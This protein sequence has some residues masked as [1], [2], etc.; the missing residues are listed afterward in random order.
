MKELVEFSLDDGDTMV[1]EI[2]QPEAE[3]GLVRAA[4][5]KA[6]G[7][8]VE[9]GKRF[10]QVT[11][12]VRPAAQTLLAAVRDLEPMRVEVE[13]GVKMSFSA[14]AIIASTSGDANFKITCS[15]ERG[16]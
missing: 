10:D 2:D 1:I 11:K 9:S 6:D 7:V 5:T 14:G 8:I 13:F 12:V 3:S 4:S 15:W 16:G